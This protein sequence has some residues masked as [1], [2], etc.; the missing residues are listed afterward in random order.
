MCNADAMTHI[1]D[2]DINGIGQNLVAHYKFH[3]IQRFKNDKVDINWNR[4]EIGID[5][6]KIFAW[7]ISEA[8]NL[9]EFNS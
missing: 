5:E 4:E 2:D 9:L 8:L 6:R 1:S 3:I 7:E